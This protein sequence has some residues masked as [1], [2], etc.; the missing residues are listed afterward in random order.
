[1]PHNLN[2]IPV[3]QNLDDIKLE[4]KTV[5]D[6]NSSQNNLQNKSVQFSLIEDKPIMVD[7]S[8]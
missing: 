2:L 1:M 7:R 6:Y 5:S 3:K 8:Q 4:G